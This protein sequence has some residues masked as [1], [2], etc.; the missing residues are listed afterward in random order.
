MSSNNISIPKQLFHEIAMSLY[1]DTIDHNWNCYC[2]YCKIHRKV[3]REIEDYEEEIGCKW[4]DMMYKLR[5]ND[6]YE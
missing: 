1:I 6:K 5:I 3:L 2:R 4:S